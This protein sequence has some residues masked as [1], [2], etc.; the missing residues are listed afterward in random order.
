MASLVDQTEILLDG[1]PD[2][3]VVA[4]LSVH[5][6]LPPRNCEDESFLNVLQLHSFF[7]RPVH[8]D[9]FFHQLL[10]VTLLEFSQHAEVYG[11][12]VE[13][14]AIEKSILATVDNQL[15]DFWVM[16]SC[17][18]K[19]SI[20]WRFDQSQERQG[21]VFVLEPQVEAHAGE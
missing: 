6:V 1:L 18:K 21:L 17:L 10:I 15:E 16:A 2:Q 11:F 19:F 4:G 14:S 7:G 3:L 9:V 5:R 8:L 13:E 20:I 12:F